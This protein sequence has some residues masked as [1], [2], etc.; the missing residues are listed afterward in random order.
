M[1]PNHLSQSLAHPITMCSL[2]ATDLCTPHR[3]IPYNQC[4]NYFP[5]SSAN[6]AFAL[7]YCSYNSIDQHMP[8]WIVSIFH[9]HSISQLI[10][11]LLPKPTFHRSKRS[12]VNPVKRVRQHLHN[13]CHT[14][15]NAQ[16]RLS[17]MWGM[18]PC[19]IQFHCIK[20]VLVSFSTDLCSRIL[21]FQK[22]RP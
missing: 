7:K 10:L 16:N 19:I 12:M 21:T 3:T 4:I 11:G 15:N 22:L 8:C 9:L 6:V 1:S 13:Y 20:L 17:L 2:Q 14:H 5:K 18:S